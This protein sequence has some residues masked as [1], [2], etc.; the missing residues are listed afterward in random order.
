MEYLVITLEFSNSWESP[1]SIALW[2][3]W[4]SEFPTWTSPNLNFLQ[5]QMNFNF[6]PL[7]LFTQAPYKEDMNSM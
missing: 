5:L 7:E 2:I 1:S 4:I 3:R 6:L